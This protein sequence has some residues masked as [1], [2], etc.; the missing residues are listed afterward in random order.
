MK[1]A[2]AWRQSG[3]GWW[4]DRTARPRT[5]AW[6]IWPIKLVIMKFRTSITIDLPRERM[7]QLFDNPV[8]LK[9]W[10]PGLLSFEPISGVPGQV[11][12]KSRLKYKMGRREFEMIETVTKRDLPHEFNGTYE[13]KGI[14][15]SVENRFEEAGPSKT[16]WHSDCDCRMQGFMKVI[17]FLM[18]GAI[19][20]ENVKMQE[21]FKAWAEKQ[22]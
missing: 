13:A 14:W 16:I 12:A 3:C 1:C 17:A 18:P 15:N 6:R 19:K 22:G 5:L 10:Q 8:T 2:F 7:I 11:G 4:D 20:R 9:E 21:R